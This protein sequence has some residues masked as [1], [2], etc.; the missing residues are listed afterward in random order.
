MTKK[1]NK[2]RSTRR[3][4]DA[5]FEELIQLQIREYQATNRHGP[6]DHTFRISELD[7]LERQVK[8]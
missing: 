4:S 7:V 8:K 3:L 1:K 5:Q 2:P 6:G